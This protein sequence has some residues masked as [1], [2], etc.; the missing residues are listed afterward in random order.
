MILVAEHQTL[1]SER[2][3]SQKTDSSD[4]LVPQMLE[5]IKQNISV[6]GFQICGD[7]VVAKQ[8]K[9]WEFLIP[10]DKEFDSNEHYSF[11]ERIRLV[12]AA[13]LR[14]YDSFSKI[15]KS[16]DKL[17]NYITE[18]KLTPITVPYIVARDD[19]DNVY[20]IYIGISENET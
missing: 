2:L 18:K 15:Q 9:F 3:L 8:D 16:L 13:R 10:V 12:N 4:D 5:Y 1:K 14:H 19:L 11:K 6:L 7:I 17:N 20:D